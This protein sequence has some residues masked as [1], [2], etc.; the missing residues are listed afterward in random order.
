MT[1]D[2]LS[3]KYVARASGAVGYDILD[4]EG[5][6]V[7]SAADGWEAAAIVELLNEQAS[8]PHGIPE[9]A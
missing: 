9:P 5:A 6:I 4:S 3:D 8:S 1:Y 2:E 7:A